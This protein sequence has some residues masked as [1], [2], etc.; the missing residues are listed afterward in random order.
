MHQI[1]Y[2]Y[3][4]NSR[5][6]THRRGHQNTRNKNTCHVVYIYSDEETEKGYSKNK[7]EYIFNESSLNRNSAITR[8]NLVYS[9]VEGQVGY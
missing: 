8:R 7:H 1:S 5:F 9:I 2:T 4:N 3:I 6:K